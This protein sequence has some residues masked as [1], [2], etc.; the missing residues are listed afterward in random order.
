MT[1]TNYDIN[2]SWH[3]IIKTYPFLNITNFLETPYQDIIND[4]KNIPKWKSIC[5]T[6]RNPYER[7]I[8]D[9]MN[10]GDSIG[11]NGFVESS[12]W[13]IM[14]VFN[15]TGKS[16]HTIIHDFLQGSG[17]LNHIKSYRLIKNHKWTELRT[18]FPSIEKWVAKKISPYFYVAFI[19]FL[20]LE[21]GGIIPPHRDIPKEILST[22]QKKISFYNILNSIAISLYQKPGNVFC[23]DNK[24]IPFKVGD[25]FWI[26]LGKEHWVVNMSNDIR[27]HLQIQGLY[28]KSYREYIVKNIEQIKKHTS[29]LHSTSSMQPRTHLSNYA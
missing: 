19:R 18:Y 28:K 22:Y 16:N 9:S 4:L 20:I 26:N 23:V 15:R 11:G 1:S 13:K 2:Q 10:I 12:G 6:P 17:M 5:N 3:Q 27:I 29:Y 25:A 14:S 21:P 7:N 8:I 24:L